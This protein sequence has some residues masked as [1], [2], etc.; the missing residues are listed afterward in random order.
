MV[1]TVVTPKE[2][3]HLLQS[4]LNRRE[5]TRCPLGCK[6]P[7]PFHRAPPKPE[8]SN[9]QLPLRACARGCDSVMH[10]IRE[11]LKKQY[12]LAGH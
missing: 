12:N 11:Q 3:R 10:N 8:C 2:L 6:V 7:P 5:P 1:R 9:W 4:E